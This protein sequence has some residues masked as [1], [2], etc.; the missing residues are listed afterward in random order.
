[1]EVHG[2]RG[3]SWELPENSIP[4]FTRAID[5]G[6]D[7]LEM[8]VVLT[9]DRKVVVSHDP[10]LDPVLFGDLVR[11]KKT[12]F[13]DLDY[14]SL[15]SYTYGSVSIPDFPEQTL[16][17]VIIPLLEDVLIQ[18]SEYAEN[19]G[20]SIGF[21]IELKHE[22]SW[23]G[24]YQFGHEVLVDS[25]MDV[26]GGTCNVDRVVLQS[27]SL[28]VIDFLEKT[29]P[30][31]RKGVILERGD[32]ADLKELTGRFNISHIAPWHEDITSDLVT[33]AQREAT[34]VIPWTV[35]SVEAMRRMISM[36]VDGIITD[37]PARLKE[38]LKA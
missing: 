37:H 15:S 2:H 22:R 25:V 10:F 30:D 26:I 11:S 34:K 14:D 6:C 13:L 23:T 8:D 7:F 33:E 5:I 12:Y 31:V 28:D 9:S 36:G 1:M 17:P 4:G 18:C 38:L 29:Y 16:Q 27:F 20:R 32:K 24:T 35:N 21:N 19:N 3:C